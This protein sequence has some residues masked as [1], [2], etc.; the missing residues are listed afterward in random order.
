MSV[1]LKNLEWALCHL[2]REYGLV[3]IGHDGRYLLRDASDGYRFLAHLGISGSL[4]R[5]CARGTLPDQHDAEE[6]V[7]AIRQS[8]ARVIASLT[9]MP[10]AIVDRDPGDEDRAP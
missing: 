8:L 10:P 6:A 5:R 3:V 1:T 7:V 2:A 9:P 4:G